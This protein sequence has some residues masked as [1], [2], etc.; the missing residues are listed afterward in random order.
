MKSRII[1]VTHCSAKKNIS[2]KKT[3]KKVK[4]DILYSSD[5]IQRF[6]RKCEE[7]NVDWAI[8]SDNYGIWFKDVN[9]C[10]YEKA[11]ETVTEEEFNQLVSDFNTKL[12][13]FDEIRF[14]YNPGR[15]HKI[16]RR[17]LSETELKS[18]VK[19]FTHLSEIL[20]R[21]QKIHK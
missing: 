4:P 18:K 16:Y 8:F 9:N 2:L 13:Y 17:V 7:S 3:N 21:Q 6:M 11:P 5:R 20:P 14:Y 10:W 1:Y 15:F 19:K 12:K